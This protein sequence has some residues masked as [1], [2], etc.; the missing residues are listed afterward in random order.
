MKKSLI[1]L[2]MITLVCMSFDATPV[3]A[4]QPQPEPPGNILRALEKLDDLKDVIG[5]V[6]A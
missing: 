4:S 2:F 1:M 3:I 5:D 6:Q